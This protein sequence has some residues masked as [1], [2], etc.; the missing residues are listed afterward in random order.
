[1]KKLLLIL[2]LLSIQIIAET[3]M[4]FKENHTSLSTI[5]QT[6]LDGGKCNSIFSLKEMKKKGWEIKDINITPNN[7]RYN[8][9]YILKKKETNEN[10]ST[11][12]IAENVINKI[13]SD[14]QIELLDKQKKEKENNIKKGRLIY[15]NCSSCHG[16]KGEI[17][18]YD[19]SEA[20]RKLSFDDM[21]FAINRYTFDEDYGNGN[22]LIMRQYA[23]NITSNKLK[24]I[25][26]YLQYINKKENK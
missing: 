16:L 4:C 12:K 5:E 17:R 2:P 9:V 19:S 22:E 21:K 23:S 11:E 26:D 24:M 25:Y 10:L 20:L 8:F 13:E 3:T 18:A 7:D 6:K 14:K 15:S 1:M